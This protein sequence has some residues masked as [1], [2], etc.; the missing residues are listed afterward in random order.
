MDSHF[1]RPLFV[2]SFMF[3]YLLILILFVEMSRKYHII[4]IWLYWVTPLIFIPIL[5]LFPDK[6][7]TVYDYIH[8]FGTFIACGLIQ[9]LRR[10]L[11]KC[12]KQKLQKYVSLVFLWFGYLLIILNIASGV[13]LDLHKQIQDKHLNPGNSL[14]GIILILT[15]SNPLNV[16]I[17]DNHFSS[18]RY[19]F[20]IFWIIGYSLWIVI[21]VY[22]YFGM[23]SSFN[24]VII[25]VLVPLFIIIWTNSDEYI[26]H[27]TYSMY[28]YECI[29]VLPFIKYHL[30]YYLL[31]NNDDTITNDNILLKDA[32][33]WISFVYGIFILIKDI[34]D[35]IISWNGITKPHDTSLIQYFTAIRSRTGDLGY[36]D[37]KLFASKTIIT[38]EFEVL[39]FQ[40]PLLRDFIVKFE[41]DDYQ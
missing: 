7:N 3:L 11:T 20:G 31:N 14:H 21:F 1:T 24:L 37:N 36:T 29:N 28:F 26:Q 19:R 33:N 17:S 16:K 15:L 10:N 30:P 25:Y 39:Q 6:T 41:K 9:I 40:S 8:L 4:Q 32:V 35:E 18:I 2:I 38:K 27:L 13:Y 12:R 23:H 5:I 22:N 34:Y